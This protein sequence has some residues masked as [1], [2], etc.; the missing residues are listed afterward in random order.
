[1]LIVG[2]SDTVP[3]LIKGLGVAAAPTIADDQYD[4]LFVVRWSAGGGAE[5]ETR[6]YG[7][8]SSR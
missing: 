2:H 3:E 8:G 4:F 5:L 7:A 1:V 6:R